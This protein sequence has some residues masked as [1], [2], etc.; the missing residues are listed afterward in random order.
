MRRQR[1]RSFFQIYDPL[2]R[3]RVAGWYDSDMDISPQNTS[4]EDLH[5]ERSQWTIRI[6][7]LGDRKFE[8][9]TANTTPEQRLEMV[10][11]LTVQAWAFKGVDVAES[12]LP[13]HLI[14]I[15]RRAG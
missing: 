7:K 11:P 1:C 6:G 5:G 13:R 10:W 8:V 15:T 12:R 2:S 9:G 3:P 14:R 4:D